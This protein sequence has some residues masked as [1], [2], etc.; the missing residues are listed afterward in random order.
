MDD[1]DAFCLF[2]LRIL[3]VCCQALHRTYVF[4]VAYRASAY[5]PIVKNVMKSLASMIKT[6]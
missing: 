3:V 6:T 4:C 2:R 1:D 5:C